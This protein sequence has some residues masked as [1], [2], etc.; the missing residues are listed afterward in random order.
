[1]AA[2][3]PI[4]K[5]LHAAQKTEPLIVMRLPEKFSQSGWCPLNCTAEAEFSLVLEETVGFW[6][7][8]R[9]LP[10]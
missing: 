7:I 1:M 8:K 4:N 3:A 10:G 5:P 6:N 9:H 2:I